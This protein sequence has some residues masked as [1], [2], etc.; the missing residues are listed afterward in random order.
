MHS[1]TAAEMKTVYKR[2]PLTT[3]QLQFLKMHILKERIKERKKA[4]GGFTVR[5]FLFDFQK[6]FI[7]PANRPGSEASSLQKK[8]ST[9]K[10]DDESTPMEAS[11]TVPEEAVRHPSS[12]GTPSNLAELSSPELPDAFKNPEKNRE[13][14]PETPEDIAKQ[15]SF[16]ILQVRACLKFFEQIVFSQTLWRFVPVLK[17]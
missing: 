16:K 11:E 17:V 4:Q 15:V 8:D 6:L 1:S 10:S 5:I 7:Y 13:S 9:L 12:P 2:P 3:G 14:E